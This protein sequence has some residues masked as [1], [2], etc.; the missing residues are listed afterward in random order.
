MAVIRNLVVKI[1]ADIGGLS[2]GLKTA[3]GKIRQISQ[4]MG[5][6][7]S[8]LTMKVTM[9]LLAIM[10]TVNKVSAGVGAVL[11]PECYYTVQVSIVGVIG[12]I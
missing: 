12:Q 8:S 7:G 5:K 3:Q 11:G 1:G 9:P 4:T 6:L 2:K 10:G